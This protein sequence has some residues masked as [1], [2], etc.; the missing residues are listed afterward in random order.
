MNTS[1]DIKMLIEDINKYS[2]ILKESYVFDG[3]EPMP[4]EQP[5]PQEGGE[6]IPPQEGEINAVDVADDSINQIR[7]LALNGIQEYSHDVESEEYN[8]FKRI[9]M[10]CDKFYTNKNKELEGKK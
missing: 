6:E 7:E 3:E 5:I 9:W 10:E 2:N 1:L 4:Q 8:I